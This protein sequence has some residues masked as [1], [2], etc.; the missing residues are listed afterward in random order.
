[1]DLFTLKIIGIISM[2]I[3]H[4]HYIIG[5][6]E[7]LNIIGRVSFPIFSFVLVEG[8]KHTRDFRK[9]LLRIG[10]SG[11]LFQIPIWI[12]K[13]TETLNIFFTLFLGLLSMYIYDKYNSYVSK[14]MIIPIG[15]AAVLLKV[16]YGIYG[17]LLIMCFYL[18]YDN[19]YMR[20]VFPLLLNIWVYFDSRIFDI[21]KIQIYSIL[22]LVP[23]FFYN[24]EKGKNAKYFFYIFYPLHFILLEAVKY[25]I[26]NSK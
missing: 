18:G 11:V 6:S 2:F 1:M 19:K 15:I 25:I 24:G 14:I 23:I 13:Y 12:L 22:G 4:Y 17:I 10:I 3:D 16:D 7:I 5:G 21:A 20:I 26:K 9:Y 8:Y